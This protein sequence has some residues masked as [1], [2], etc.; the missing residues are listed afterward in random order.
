MEVTNRPRRG[1]GSRA[2]ASHPTHGALLGAAAAVLDRDGLH[3][4]SIETVTR[5]A[6]FGKGTFYLHFDDRA[7][8]LVELHRQ[9]HDNVFDSITQATS[10]MSPGLPRA[11]VRILSFLDGCRGQPGV[12]AI[13]LQARSEPAVAAEVR[14]RN[15]QAAKLLAVDLGEMV[16]HPLE[17]AR[18]LVAATAE[19]AVLELQAGRKLP[20]LR[21]ALT[22][23]VALHSSRGQQ[24]S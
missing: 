4:L 16:V 11:R 14:R 17:T 1:P 8:L 22:E 10:S 6:G 2:G 12:R 18:L 20:R 9:F 13:L 21:A 7:A 24:H 19:V 5:E 15:D 3:A 23:L